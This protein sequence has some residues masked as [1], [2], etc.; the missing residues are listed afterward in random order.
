MSDYIGDGSQKYKIFQ[1]G[2]KLAFVSQS[3]TTGLWVFQDNKENGASI[4]PDPGQ[5]QGSWFDV[6]RASKG[7]YANKGYLINTL[8]GNRCLTIYG[9]I[10]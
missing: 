8:A 4:K 9:G 6:V 2:T 10:C 1:N 3:T 7:Q 5:H